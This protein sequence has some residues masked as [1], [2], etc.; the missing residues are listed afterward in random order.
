MRY[1][2]VIPEKP[3][4]VPTVEA[5]AS[6]AG[7]FIAYCQAEVAGAPKTTVDAK[8]RDFQLFLDYFGKM[9]RSDSIDDWTQSVTLEFIQGL[10]NEANGGKG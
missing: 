4:T 10:E 8:R 3:A 9:M 6:L 7:W 2:L 5:E 1:E